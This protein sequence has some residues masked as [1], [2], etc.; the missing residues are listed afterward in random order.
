MKP[1]YAI[2]DAIQIS[3]ADAAQPDGP[4]RFDVVAYTGGPMRVGGYSEPV[5]VDLEG[6]SFGKSIIANLDHDRSKRVGHVTDKSK[7]GGKLTLGGFASAAT[8]FRDEVI[9]SARD[10]FVWQ[11]SIEAQPTRLVELDA[12][13][14][15]VVNGQTITGPAI[16]ARKS[17]LKGFAF[18]SHGAD[19]NTTAT[20]AASAASHRETDMAQQGFEAW[21]EAMG[22][23]IATLTD[24]QKAGLKANFNGKN[25]P[26]KAKRVGDVVAELQAEQEREEAIAAIVAREARG[27]SSAEIAAIR[28]LADRA[29]SAKQD[30]KEFELEVLRACRPQ[31]HTVFSRRS[32]ENTLSNEV[33]E[34]AVCLSGKLA[35]VENHF[36]EQTLDAAEKR[37]PNGIGLKE[38]FLI[39]A[40]ANGHHTTGT[41]VDRNVLKAAFAE[42]GSP[43][44]AS[45]GFS[46]LSVPGILSNIAN[47]YLQVGF[48]S[49]DS[50]WRSISAIASVRDF[51]TKTSYTLTGAFE[52]EKVGP[53]GELKHGTVG[54]ETYTNKADT[55][56]KM[57]AITRTDI[58]ND[59]LSAL[60]AVPQ[61]LGRGAGLKM[62]DVFWTEFLNNSSFFSTG[63]SNVS[64]GA[65]SALSLAGLTAAELKFLNQTDPNGKPLGLMPSILLVPPTLKATAMQL[66]QSQL[67]IDGTSTAAQGNANVFAGRFAVV[68][69]PYMENSSYTGYSAAAWYLL[70]NPMD[71][72]TI[73]MCFLN[74]KETPTVEQAD[75]DFATLGVQMRGYHDFG[76]NLQEPRAGVRSAGS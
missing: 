52:Y 65:G 16:I 5:V 28:E 54:E 23:D 67:L 48:L 3:A 27:R 49:V 45:S 8:A 75:A 41:N 62:N 18:V 26:E 76:C 14:T 72:A 61:R 56:G 20:I 11:A 13:K 58:I 35:K 6:M 57:F 47:K 69:S 29:I 39:A 42:G 21:V 1:I 22:F 30:V 19:D 44:H 70:A 7:E 64:T 9:A 2:S 17:V 63:N 55:Y 12:G 36:S 73:E 24:E 60:T 66:M 33:I 59:D 34:A 53:G 50:A 38:I 46:T 51:K 31:A 68:S 37:F 74:G 40:G 43:I 25:A 10:G 71:L 32:R 4:K 15:A